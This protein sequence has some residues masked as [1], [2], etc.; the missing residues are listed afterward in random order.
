MRLVYRGPA[1]DGDQHVFSR[2][3]R[4]SETDEIRDKLPRPHIAVWLWGGLSAVRLPA[5]VSTSARLLPMDAGWGASSG[6]NSASGRTD[7]GWAVVAAPQA[8]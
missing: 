3:N 5:R 2:V 7:G 4:G 8:D 6:L 1:G